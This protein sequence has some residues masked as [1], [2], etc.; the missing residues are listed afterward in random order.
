MTDVVI[1]SGHGLRNEA[2]RRDQ[3]YKYCFISHCFHS[4]RCLRQLCIS[5]NMEHF[6]GSGVHWHHTG[7]EAFKRRELGLQIRKWLW[8]LLIVIL[9]M[10]NA[11]YNIQNISN[12]PYKEILWQKF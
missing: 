5:N 10:Q 1:N 2:C 8:V 9:C 12:S 7:I 6:K 3:P 4:Y 11:K